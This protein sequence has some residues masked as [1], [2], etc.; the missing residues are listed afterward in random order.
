MSMTFRYASWRAA[1]FAA[2]VC[3]SAPFPAHAAPA[4][5]PAR[6]GACVACHGAQGEGSAAGAPRLA[7]QNAQYLERALSMFKAGTRTSPVMQAVVGGLDDA[8]I[9]ELASY[10]AGLRGVPLAAAAPPSADLVRAGEELARVGAASDSTPA[11]FSCHGAAARAANARFPA[12]EGQP[13]AFM[14][15]RLHEFQARAREKAPQ[16]ATMT[17]VAARLSEEQIRQ[18]AAYIATLAPKQ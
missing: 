12:I 3:L 17:A 7:G 6:V 5:S 18:L 9:H 11:C 1:S 10:F 13:A 2:A 16:P 4:E 14:V 8:E 15:N